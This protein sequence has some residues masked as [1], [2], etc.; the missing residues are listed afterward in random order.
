MIFISGIYRYE[1]IPL[2]GTCIL[3]KFSV[4]KT[5]L[6]YSLGVSAFSWLGSNS[7]IGTC[8]STPRNI[9]PPRFDIPSK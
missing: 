2:S 6:R 3:L 5:D 4:M 9:L 7:P 1:D 8:Q